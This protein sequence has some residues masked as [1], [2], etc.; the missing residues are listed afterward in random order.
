MPDDSSP[1]A[2][3]GRLLDGIAN[4]AWSDLHRLYAPGAVVDYPFGL[5]APSR[6]D[7]LPAIQRYFAGV[8]RAPLSLRAR[9]VV[10]HETA[11]PEVVVVEWTYD[12]T[13]TN[14]GRTFEVANI[15][16]TRVR[17]GLIVASRDYHNHFV[18]AEVTGR[19]PTVLAALG[20]PDA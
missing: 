8:S 4:G 16:V 18:L 7:G 11:D 3:V 12:G 5:P 20:G 10:V 9:D 15:Q 14:T 17:D 1:R 13:V 19:L 6:L 2:V